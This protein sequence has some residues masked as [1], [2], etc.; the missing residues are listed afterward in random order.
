M[1][2]NIDLGSK[3]SEN[4]VINESMIKQ[5][6]GGDRI[7]AREMYSYTNLSGVI[8]ANIMTQ[9]LNVIWNEFRRFPPETNL[10][11]VRINDSA[12][13]KVYNY[14]TKEYIMSISMKNVYLLIDNIN[15]CDELKAIREL[16]EVENVFST[17]LVN[18]QI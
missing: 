16:I 4:S 3:T 12:N 9:N 2:I 11:L 7:S 17:A 5:I 15:S 1:S 8:K 10:Q 6:T 18:L 13:I 14:Q